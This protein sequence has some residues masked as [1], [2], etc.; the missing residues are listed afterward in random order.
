MRLTHPP[1]VGSQAP[2]PGR[3]DRQG[4]GLGADSASEGASGSVCGLLHLY[5]PAPF[6]QRQGVAPHTFLSSPEYMLFLSFFPF[7]SLAALCV[8]CGSSSQPGIVP[9]SLQWKLRP[10]RD[11]QEG[12]FSLPHS[13]V[14]RAF[15]SAASAWNISL[16]TLEFLP[17]SACS[18]PFLLGRW[19]RG[20]G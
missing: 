4:C 12:L 17:I 2:Q 11:C 14:S 6:S 15:A 16:S 9:C 19:S 5:L 10:N 1:L 18:C 7:F 8:P 3:F 13:L 20:S